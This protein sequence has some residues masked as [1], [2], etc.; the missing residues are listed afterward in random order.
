MDTL[1]ELQPPLTLP[2]CGAMPLPRIMPG[3]MEGIMTPWFCRAVTALQLVDGWMTPF[4]RL[5]DN[6]P[7]KRKFA[8]FLT[9][10][11]ASGQP[12]ILQL[13]GCDAGLMAEAAALTAANFPLS[14][15]DVNF[16]C[17]SP[18]VLRSGGGG[19]MLQHPSTMLAIVRA[20]RTA[21]PRLPLSVKLRTGYASDQEM[22]DYLPALADSGVDFFSIHYRTVKEVYQ[23]APDRGERLRRAVMLANRV[24][25]LGSGDVYTAT[26]AA[27]LVSCGCAGIMG[28]RGWLRDPWLLRRLQGHATALA[29]DAGRQCF[30]QELQK[31]ARQEPAPGPRP[32]LTGLAAYLWGAQDPRFRALLKLTDQEFWSGNPVGSSVASD[33]VSGPDTT[34]GTP[35]NSL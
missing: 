5:S 6:L 17:P 9:P 14:G 19:A 26:D 8:D 4:F 13:M 10:F 11:L 12:V 23:V 27:E 1:T 20:M 15:I 7:R 30:F 3:P 34:P 29:P 35:G 22:A 31:Q 16:A 24:P 25:V 21:L 28:A 32:G 2:H 33:S 18:T